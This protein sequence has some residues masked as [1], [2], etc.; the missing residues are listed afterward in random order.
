MRRL[1]LAAL[2]G[3]MALLA[4]A[5]PLFA[6]DP[7]PTQVSVWC[8]ADDQNVRADIEGVVLV[9]D[10]SHG[11]VDLRLLGSNGQ[12]KSNEDHGNSGWKP[13][14]QKLEVKIVR[15]QT[16]YH[17]D[18]NVPLSGPQFLMYRVES[19]TGVKS[20]ILDRDE[21]GF[22]VPEAPA[23]GL[24]LLA[25]GIP[26]AGLLAVRYRHRLLPVRLPHLG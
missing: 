8:S 14:G 13:T 10:G 7:K 11:D 5:S 15:G 17:F 1:L 6:A 20:R 22:R 9:P 2:V 19:S 21:C 12:G 25:G 16:A 23:P 18:F 26:G 3:V 4:T 24:L